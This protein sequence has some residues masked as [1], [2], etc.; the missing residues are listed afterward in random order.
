MRVIFSWRAAL[1]ILL[2]AGPC[3][4]KRLYHQLRSMV[5]SSFGMIFQVLSDDMKVL[6]HYRPF[7]LA[8]FWACPFK[9]LT[10][11]L[12]IHDPGD[13]ERKHRGVHGF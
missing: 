1:S 6:G 2:G 8:P 10:Y 5:E 12:P 9:I 11:K 4:L 3:Y 7:W 13:V